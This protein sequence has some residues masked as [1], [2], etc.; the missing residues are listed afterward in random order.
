M[1]KTSFFP[2]SFIAQLKDAVNLSSI[3]SEVVSLKRAGRN[4]QGLCPFH[5]EKTPSFMVNEEKQI[6]HCFGCGLGGNVFTFLMQYHHLSFPEAVN[7]L[8]QR[9]NIPLPMN[10]SG[11]SGEGEQ[12]LKEGLRALQT[13][14]AEFYHHLLM[15]GKIGQKG[16]DYLKVRKMDS[17]I[18]E[19]FYLGYAPEGWDRLLSF[20]Q[21]KKVSPALLEQTGL[22]IKKEKGGYYDRF[23]NRLLFPIF[24]DRKQV[25]GFGGR[26]LGGETPKYLNSPESA[27]FNKGR[28]FFGFP[29]AAK[30]IRSLNQVIVVEGYFDLLALHQHGFKHTV[31]T[32]GTA[33]SSSQIRKLHGLAEDIILLFD[34]DTPGIQAA[35]R[36]VPLFQQEG[37]S[38]RVKVL[39]SDSDP[40][41]FL[42]EYGAERFSAE[43]HQA[44]PMMS[45]FF[46]QQMRSVG[47]RVEDQARMLDRLM[48]HLRAL[49]SEWERAHYVALISE[50]LKIPEGVIWKSL[51]KSP[52]IEKNRERIQKSIQE[53]HISGLE[54]RVLEALLRLPQAVPLLLNGGG[55]DLFESADAKSIYLLIKEIY[56]QQGKVDIS[57]LLDRLTDQTLKNKIS[58]MAIQT[59]IDQKD[60]QIFLSDLSKRVH[61]RE[62]QQREK[63]LYEEIRAKEKS[64]INEELRALL[65]QK[66]SLLQKRKAILTSSNE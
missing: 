66:K 37:V 31:A 46:K 47:I 49:A 41:S 29:Q 28:L 20:F 56:R 22:I 23:R 1:A 54:W 61:L 9:L 42:F 60:E 6:F 65:A 44:E 11:R 55:G 18:A 38:P 13:Q 40:D 62:L 63:A 36:S 57:L 16:R 27:V 15:K 3:V 45:F 30:E 39:P 17:R 24:D 26:A 51:K 5:P 25:I 14:A 43:L 53:E 32:M 7:E 19:E 4:L 33:L 8:A 52:L 59:F 58:A 64:G 34:G 10:E 2:E 35:M 50:K 48:P 12:R 21:N